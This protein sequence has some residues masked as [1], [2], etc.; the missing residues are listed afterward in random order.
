MMEPNLQLGPGF[1]SYLTQ[2]LS[3]CHQLVGDFKGTLFLHLTF[4]LVTRT[5]EASALPT[6]DLDFQGLC[7]LHGAD[8]AKTGLWILL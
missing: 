7:R 5:P 8:L 1:T 6:S 3:F 4:L 2:D